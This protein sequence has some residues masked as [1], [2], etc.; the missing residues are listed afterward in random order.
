MI[1][2]KIV[3]T[4]GFSRGELDKELERVQRP[5]IVSLVDAGQADRL[6]REIELITGVSVALEKAG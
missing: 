1:K 4:G 5:G 2:Y 6:C 3:P